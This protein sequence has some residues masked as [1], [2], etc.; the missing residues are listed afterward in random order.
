MHFSRFGF[1]FRNRRMVERFFVLFCAIFSAVLV[2]SLV[3]LV[4]VAD[5]IN[6]NPIV[7]ILFR[8]FQRPFVSALI[9]SFFVTTLLYAVFV[10]VHPVQHHTVY[11]QRHS[12]RY[13]IRKKSHIHRRLRH[14]P[15]QT[16][17]K[18]LALSS[19]FVVV[20]I[21]FVSFASG[22]LPH[23]VL[24]Q[25]VDPSGQKSQSVLV[26]AFYVQ[27]LDSDDLYIW[28]FMLGLLPLAVLIF[29][30]VF[31]S[32]IFPHKNFHYESAHLDTNIVTF[33]ARK[34]AEQRRKKPSPPA[35]IVPLHD[36]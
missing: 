12:Q 5:K 36:A 15:A 33:A 3:A 24:A 17:H 32:H 18:L 1:Y 11:W 16:S 7:H 14:I 9:L 28:I 34:K 8:F 4:L 26:A 27:V 10:L 6:I 21:V 31:R 35:G 22:F 19:L 30:I 25:T 29:F 13:H 2:L 23:D 20:K